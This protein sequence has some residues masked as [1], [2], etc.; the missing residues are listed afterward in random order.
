MKR[1]AAM[2]AFEMLVIVIADAFLRDDPRGAIAL[3]QQSRPEFEWN[4]STR[5]TQGDGASDGRHAGRRQKDKTGGACPM[6]DLPPS[7]RVNHQSLELS[8]SADPA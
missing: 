4:H 1:M 5:T 2:A 3:E 7:D 8:N 6:V